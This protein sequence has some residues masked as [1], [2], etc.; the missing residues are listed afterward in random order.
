MQ[1]GV[2]T[3]NF[4]ADRSNQNSLDS[5]CPLT[6]SM[7]DTISN[8]AASLRFSHLHSKSAP[9][10]PSTH[11]RRAPPEADESFPWE[12]GRCHLGGNIPVVFDDQLKPIQIVGRRWACPLLDAVI[13]A[14]TV[15]AQEN[16]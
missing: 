9:H 5:F 15:G 13:N 10:L 12:Q 1:S 8:R 2:N 7:C 16:P 4:Q 14:P 3:V 6:L 11:Q